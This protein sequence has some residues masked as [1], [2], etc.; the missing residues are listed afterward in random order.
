MSAAGQVTFFMAAV[1]CVLRASLW[2]VPANSARPKGLGAALDCRGLGA[3]LIAPFV[4]C[5]PR[6]QAQAQKLLSQTQLTSTSWV[7]CCQLAVFVCFFLFFYCCL[8]QRKG[9]G[10]SFERCQ[11][12]LTG[13][14]APHYLVP[15]RVPACT[16]TLLQQKFGCWGAGRK[17]HIAQKILGITWF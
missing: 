11:A 14:L 16:Q 13:Q 6:R 3:P 1:L 9:S 17:M 8:W 15:V 12:M 5:S 4:L 2:L 10:L 7:S